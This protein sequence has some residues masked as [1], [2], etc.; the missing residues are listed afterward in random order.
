MPKQIAGALTG[1]LVVPILAVVLGLVLGWVDDTRSF[2]VTAG[3]AAV[4][5]APLGWR[6]PNVFLYT[7][8]CFVE[9][10]FWD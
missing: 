2:Y 3:I 4:F 5:G 7:V 1:L 9:E 8:W 10:S 6:W